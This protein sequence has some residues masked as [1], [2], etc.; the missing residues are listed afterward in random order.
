MQD[1]L[2]NNA[3]LEQEREQ[4]AELQRSRLIAEKRKAAL[5]SQIFVVTATY[6]RT[7]AELNALIVEVT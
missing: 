7:Q 3:R 2:A 5:H 6:R 1:E 4:E